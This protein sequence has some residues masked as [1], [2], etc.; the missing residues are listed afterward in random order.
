VKRP[1]IFHVLAERELEEAA[2][3]YGEALPSIGESF[4][5]EVQRAVDALSA[6]PLA[7]RVV[8]GDVRWWL[9]R[10]FPYSVL[11]RIHGERIRILSI[12]HQKRRP[13]FWRGRR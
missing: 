13:L 11:Y 4:V 8:E 12:A 2:A 5:S 10:R 3:Y 7:G 6:M 1:A 9:V